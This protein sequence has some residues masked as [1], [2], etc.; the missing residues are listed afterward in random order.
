MTPSV[1]EQLK[2]ARIEQK[3][4]LK[5][6]ATT[7]K[8]QPWVL[9]ALEA[10]QRPA[11]I[12]QIYVKGFLSSYAKFLRLNPEPLLAQMFPPPVDSGEADTM[13]A[14]QALDP[15]VPASWLPRW[16]FELPRLPLRR[17]G[18]VALSIVG[19]LVVVNAQ[20]WR[21]LS[22]PVPRQEA[23]LSLVTPESSSPETTLTTF[24]LQPT[25]L[26][27][28]AILARQATWI[29]VTGDGKLLTQQL[30]KAGSQETWRVKRRFEVIIAK[31]SQVEVVLNGQSIS[32]LAMAH[33]GRFV[34]THQQITQL[35][36]PSP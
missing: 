9:E 21:W 1:G 27:E 26:L 25:E 29:S 17:L 30:L 19:L 5:D 36:D 3:L 34:I 2:K 12:N 13:S 8:I 14:P 6:I 4:S 23:S 16:S 20:P 32:P 18:T 33:H 15:S 35:S 31:P 10:D 24:N 11:G 22:R 7:T 28:L